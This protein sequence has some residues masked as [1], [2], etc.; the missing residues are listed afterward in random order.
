ME[1]RWNLRGRVA[2]VTGGSEGIG[3]AAVEELARLGARVIAVARDAGRLERRVAEWG[4]QGLAVLPVAADVTDPGGVEAIVH[5]LGGEGRLDILVNNVGTNIRAATADYDAATVEHLVRIN[6]TSA[7]TVCQACHPLLRRAGDACVVNVA[8]VA[9]IRSVGTGAPYAMSKAGML[10]LT[11]YLA[12]EWAPDG[13]RVNAVAP[14]YIRTPLTAP[15]LADPARLER[16]LER[17]PLGRVGEPHEVAAVI[18]FLCMPAA[19]YVTG[20]CVAVDGGFSVRGL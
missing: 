9:G 13:I 16:I 10:Q 12:V 5:A 14:W 15:V 8:S 4:E 2:V 6:L 1:D 20:Q 11:R 3:R 19:A 7:F 17:T 18:A